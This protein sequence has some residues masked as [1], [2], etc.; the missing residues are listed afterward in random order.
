MRFLSIPNNLR[1]PIVH[2]SQAM[3][4]GDLLPVFKDEGDCLAADMFVGFTLIKTVKANA[5]KDIQSNK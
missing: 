3:Q 2:N 4:F 1:N 5:L